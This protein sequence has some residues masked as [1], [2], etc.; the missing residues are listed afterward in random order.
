[1]VDNSELSGAFWLLD[2]GASRHF[3]GDI[4]DF[5]SY[6]ELKRVHY[7]KMANGVALIAGIGMVLL[8]CLDQNS[9]DEKVVTLTQCSICQAL[10]HTLFLWVKCSSATIESLAIREALASLAKLITYGLG[11][12]QKMITTSFLGLDLSQ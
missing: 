3:T 9:G 2:S 1:M 11:Q 12:T 6:N 4:G 7:A 5:A 8:Q 10:L